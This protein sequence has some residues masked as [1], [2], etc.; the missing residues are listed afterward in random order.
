MSTKEQPAWERD[1]RRKLNDSLQVLST[2]H[3]GTG[4]MQAA[5]TEVQG[6]SA[7]LAFYA[8]EKAARAMSSMARGTLIL[9]G[10]TVLL[11]VLQ[12]LG[13]LGGA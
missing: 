2:S 5:T 3:H 7:Y 8:Q 4:T 1:V 12:L 6:M 10:A 9:A 13:L 11:V